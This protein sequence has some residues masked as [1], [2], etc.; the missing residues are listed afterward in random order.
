MQMKQLRKLAA[1]A[2]LA[3]LAVPSALG[4]GRK[5]LRINEVMVVNDSSIVDDYGRHSALIELVNT[6]NA[7]VKISAVY[8]PYDISNPRK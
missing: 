3:L 6:T 4:Q 8:M 5:E 7:N 2:A 1:L